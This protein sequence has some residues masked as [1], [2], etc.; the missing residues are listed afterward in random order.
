M[1]KVYLLFLLALLP[2]VVYADP[3]EINGIYYNLVSKVK[4]A[5]VT[6]NP[7]K[8]SCD[9]T[10]PTTVTYGGNEYSVVSIDES[11]FNSCWALTSIIIPN[12]VNFIASGTFLNCRSLT[13]VAI[14]NS[15]IYIG[16]NAFAGCSSLTSVNIPNSVTY[17]DYCAFE[18]CGLTSVVIPNSVTFIGHSAFYDCKDLT[19]MSISN[20]VTFI[21]DDAF[22]GCSSLTSVSIP[23]SVTSICDDTFKNCSS[24]TSVNIPNSV[25]SIGKDAFSGCSSLTSVTIPNSVTSIGGYAFLGC[26][27]LT[28]IAIGSDIT[29]IRNYSF[30]GCPELIDFYCM[31][32]DVPDTGPNAFVGSYIEYATLHVPAGSV[33][34]YKAVEPWSGFKEI[35]PIAESASITIG[36]RIRRA[37]SRSAFSSGRSSLRRSLGGR[38]SSTAAT[39]RPIRLKF[40]GNTAPRA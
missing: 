19:S 23:N 2:F 1:K 4:T 12:S 9:V 34:A 7:N 36:R 13:S 32:E 10:I 35:L 16:S 21:D 38:S 28:S 3:V 14:P 11:A 18:G 20:S 37:K 27:D 39:P 6:S 33:D 31:A 29:I 15:V 25:T 8:Y 40:S 17:I 22:N 26:R 30:S 24:L 5:E